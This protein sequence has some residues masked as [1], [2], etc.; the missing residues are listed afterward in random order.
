MAG[1]LSHIRVLDLSRVLAGP[2]AGQNLADLGAEVIKVERPKVGD[3][4]RAY[5]PPWIKNRDGKDTRDSAY[6]T[7]A[8]RGK[9]S[10]TIDLASKAGQALVRELVLKCDVLLENY[11]FGDLARYGL[12]YEDLAQLNPRLIYCSVT[13]FGQTGPQRQHPGFDFMIQGMGGMMSVTGEPDGAPGGG[14]QRAGVP[15]ADIITGM[16]ASIAICAALTSRAETGKGQHLDLALLDSQIALLAYQ[17]TNYFATGMPPKR[18]GNLHPNIVPYQPFRTRDGDIIVACGNDNLYRKLCEAAGCGALATDERFATN[19][20]R[21][22]NREELTRL[23]QDVFSGRTT[24]E[25]IEILEAAGVPNGPI[26]NVAQVFQEPQVKARGIRLKLPHPVAGEVDSVASPM[27]FSGTPLAFERAPPLLGQH[28]DEV[29]R[30]LL[31]KS[32]AE[33][34][35]LRADGT[36]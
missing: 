34:A 23:L 28:T 4:S 17:N 15:V 13:G 33:L 25:W 35:R 9:K 22:E 26:N 30:D 21:V 14:P 27:R 16:Y 10:I 8:N 3:D 1:P 24:R 29:L 36:V 11:K 6:F 7:C 12:G 2:W 31:G 18:I 32:D 20:K 19:G 5:G